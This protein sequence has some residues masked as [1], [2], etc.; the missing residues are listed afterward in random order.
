MLRHCRGSR[1]IAPF[2]RCKLLR[3]LTIQPELVLEI[4]A[5]EVPT[6][7]PQGGVPE[8]PG[9]VPLRLSNPGFDPVPTWGKADLPSRAGVE[10]LANHVNKILIRR[11]INGLFQPLPIWL[12]LLEAECRVHDP[13]PDIIVHARAGICVRVE[14]PLLFE[15]VHDLSPLPFLFI[16]GVTDRLFLNRDLRSKPLPLC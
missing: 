12:L 8:M 10:V 6:N 7:D 2:K 11:L 1:M 14:A 15:T 5:D 9:I 3:Q 4:E 16:L 13:R